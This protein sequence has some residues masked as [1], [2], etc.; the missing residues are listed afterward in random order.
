MG[1]VFEMI[2]RFRQTPPR[3]DALAVPLIVPVT[4][5]SGRTPT[6]P[7]TSRLGFPYRF[8]APTPSAGASRHAWRTQNKSIDSPGSRYFCTKSTPFRSTCADYNPTSDP[9]L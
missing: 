1:T 7:V 5:V 4:T 8:Q 6:L 3:D 2:E 9:Q